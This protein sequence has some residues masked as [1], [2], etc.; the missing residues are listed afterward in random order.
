MIHEEMYNIFSQVLRK[1]LMT[2]FVLVIILVF[3][4]LVSSF[5]YNIK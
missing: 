5:I 4:K 3:V 2:F 1:G